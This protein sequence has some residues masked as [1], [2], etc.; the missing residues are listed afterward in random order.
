MCDL[1]CYVTDMQWLPGATRPGVP[2]NDVFAAACSDGTFKIIARGGRLEKSVDAHRGA[3]T[4][5]RWNGDGTAIL[6]V[7]EDGAVKTWSRAGLLRATLEQREAA[8]YCASWSPSEDAALYGCGKDLY[9]KPLAPGSKTVKWKAHDGVVLACDWSALNG[10]IVSGGEDCKYKVWDEHGR[11]L[12]Q[13]ARGDHAVTSVAWS[14]SGDAFAAGSFNAVWLCDET[15]WSVGKTRTEGGSVLRLAWNADGTR[16]AGAGARG[17]VTFASVVHRVVE[18]DS[19]E[20]TLTHPA[21]VD[22]RDVAAETS[23]K[24]EFRDRVVKMSLA[25]GYLVVVTSAQAIVYRKGA[26]TSPRAFDVKDVV[27]LVAQSKTCLMLVTG[28]GCHV[29]DYEGRLMSSPR[30]P[31]LRPELLTER[32]ASLSTDA[33]AHVD[34]TNPRTVRFVDVSGGKPIGTEVVHPLEMTVVRLNQTGSTVDRRVAF[35]DR[36]RDLHV[37]TMLTG[38]TRKFTSMVDSARWSASSDMLAATADE[39][40]AVWYYPD[41]AFVDRDLAA[42]TKL[43]REGDFGKASRLTYFDGKRAAV[44][45]VDGAVIHVGVSAHVPTLYQHVL[46]NQW[47]RAIRLCRFVKDDAMWSCL[48]A[49]AVAAKDLNVAEIAYAAIEEVEKVQ[50]IAGIKKVPTE[51]GRSAELALF[52]RKPDEAEAILVQAGLI[53]RA[54][55]MRVRLFDWDRALDLAVQHKTHVDTVIYH[56]NKYLEH[57]GRRETNQKFV[58]VSRGLEVNE[59]QVLMKVEQ[60]REREAQRPGARRA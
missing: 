2:A 57:L 4:A 36:N 31:G 5:I 46:A 22:V 13:S 16:V 45:R 15:G 25:H 53:Y 23:E 3:A 17:S 43:V 11:L 60:E 41:A 48:A 47:D 14:P 27:T 28:G 24:L 32:T 52:R 19:L 10:T 20:A 58:E 35:V 50:F 26:W 7:G 42:R 8:V 18:D 44:R 54:V 9:V 30:S 39:K 33:L 37:A 29:Y 56:R 40:L 6:T 12:F 55:D 1:E 38:A 21:R 49:M 51:E 59:E 34:R